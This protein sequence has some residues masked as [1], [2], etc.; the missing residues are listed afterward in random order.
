[1]VGS[2]EGQWPD[3]AEPAELLALIH[4]S[5]G[6]L[7]KPNGH[8][9]LVLRHDLPDTEFRDRTYAPCGV[10]GFGGFGFASGCGGW[11][12]FGGWGGRSEDGRD[13][14]SICYVVSYG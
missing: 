11:G 7:T 6:E 4:A 8:R 1:M 2:E 13:V 10:W 9:Q 3:R 12:G 5:Q 14:V